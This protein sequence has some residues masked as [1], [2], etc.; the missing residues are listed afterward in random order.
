MFE[1]YT[2][3]YKFSYLYID[4]VY[5]LYIFN[6]VREIRLSQS[7]HAIFA[8]H[9]CHSMITPKRRKRKYAFKYTIYEKD[10]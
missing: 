7:C 1:K 3:I 5:N 2:F 8:H 9:G 10:I 4:I 6:C